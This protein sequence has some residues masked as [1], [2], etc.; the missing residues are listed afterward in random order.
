M[1]EDWKIQLLLNLDGIWRTRAQLC[2]PCDT[3]RNM[4]HQTI[5]RYLTELRKEGLVD[6]RKVSNKQTEYKR[7]MTLAEHAGCQT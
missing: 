5:V 4:P 7:A 2:K 1:T 6:Y 3:L